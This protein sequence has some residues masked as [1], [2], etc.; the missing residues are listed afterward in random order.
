MKST[1]A[2]TYA[3]A[4]ELTG[5]SGVSLARRQDVLGIRLLFLHEAL[6]VFDGKDLPLSISAAPIQAPDLSYVRY[7]WRVPVTAAGIRRYAGVPR[8]G[9]V[10]SPAVIA[11][12]PGEAATLVLEWQFDGR[13]VRGRYTSDTTERFTLIVNGCFSPA[14][15][16]DISLE[17]C[18]LEQ[19][20]GVLQV[21]LRG[22]VE[23]P[24][25][26]D[27][28]LALQQVWAGVAGV[29]QGS[30]AAAYPVTLGPGQSLSFA[31]S[32]QDCDWNDPSETLAAAARGYEEY[33][34]RSTGDFDGAAEAVTSLSGYSRT[35]DPRRQSLQTTVNRTWGGVNQPG[36]VFGWDN[37]FTSFISAWEDPALA[38]A[39]LEHI[40]GV[41]GENGIRNGPTQRNLIIP[42]M[43][44]R[45][46][47]LLGDYELARRTWD[48]MM[49]FMRFWFP[50]RDGNRDGLIESGTS[51][52]ATT[53]DPGH[54]I[55][56]A[57]DE[58]GYDEIAI[59]SAGFTDGRRG[60]LSPGVRFD[61]AS[62]CLTVTLVCQNSLYITACRAMSALGRMIGREEDA[63]WL[64]A[65]AERVTQRMRGHLFCGNEGIFRDRFW[66]G[67]FSPVT[68]M[69]VFF[70]LL[71][72]ITDPD[73]EK[74]LFTILTD[75]EQFWGDNLIPTVSRRDPTYCD[76][77]GGKGN[78]WRGNCWA[79]TTYM[80]CLAA[81][82]AGWDEIVA[83]YGRRTQVQFMEYW[84]AHAHAYEN[85][86]PEGKVDHD[87]V[88]VN[89]WGGREIRYVWAA[90][91]L[92]CG[93][94][95]LFGVQVEGSLQFGNPF[96]S[97]QSK[98]EG[99]IYQ[100]RR[101]KAEAGPER[102]RVVVEGAWEFIAQPGI[103][104][105][106]FVKTC[107]EIRFQATAV[108]PARIEIL[109]SS[110]SP[111]AIIRIAGSEVA[112]DVRPGRIQFDLPSG[113][114]E[115]FIFRPM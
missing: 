23:E 38:A 27:E 29:K 109:E 62:Q 21:K 13:T 89:M 45:T 113:K 34:M 112:A 97:R 96:L 74:K 94:E 73:T 101:V 41:Y 26:F 53:V 35:Y 100:G 12:E 60:L 52:D 8:R 33:R 75:P 64:D 7:E 28:M 91:M 19:G 102:L 39:S 56:E 114:S 83:E 3:G 10:N 71:A 78:Y 42:V 77:F 111:G 104:V 103:A 4:F 2:V 57:M 32:L 6:G 108:M 16:I 72:G 9:C 44:C 69:T 37:F 79:P 47:H 15:V 50:H 65:E 63:A 22:K 67:E 17:E 80:V 25:V 59:Y 58:T 18:R 106:N 76:G 36:L 81:K 11:Y 85:Y 110:L 14:R 84:R 61:R 92:F 5:I 24:F 20:T 46:I 115:I 90:M 43:Y 51:R 49:E 93:L 87:F 88:F 86:P 98:W 31:M 66:E 68:A 55:Q 95:E 30:A 70:P 48:T 82:A 105:R 54:L 40:V 1:P 107:G 99:F